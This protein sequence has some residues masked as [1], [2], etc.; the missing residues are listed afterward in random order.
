VEW[1]K[2]L[3]GLF[4]FLDKLIDKIPLQGRVER[5]KN[6]IDSLTREKE[7]ILKGS[8]DE[9]KA[10]RLDYINNRLIE[11]NQLCKNKSDA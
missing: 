8:A 10:K 6:E 9:K 3:M 11:L 4:S 7:E 5:W 2:K 1:G